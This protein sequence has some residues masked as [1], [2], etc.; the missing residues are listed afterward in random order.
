MLLSN[1]LKTWLMQKNKCI[2]ECEMLW[3][4]FML[5]IF[6]VHLSNRKNIAVLR[7]SLRNV[8]FFFVTEDFID[9]AAMQQN[10]W[11]WEISHLSEVRGQPGEESLCLVDSLPFLRTAG[12]RPRQAGLFLSVQSDCVCSFLC[13]EFSFFCLVVIAVDPSLKGV[14]CRVV[15][16]YTVQQ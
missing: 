2:Y 14:F 7:N 16:F 6:C 15:C 13:D 10:V 5:I 3:E 8:F 12:K 11:R 1:T 9:F 4:I